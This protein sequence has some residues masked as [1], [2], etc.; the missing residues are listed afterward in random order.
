MGDGDAVADAKQAQESR[1]AALTLSPAEPDAPSSYS[2]RYRIGTTVLYSFTLFATGMGLGGRGAALLSLAK[3]TGI[4]TTGSGSG[5]EE[6]DID[7][8]E[9]TMVGWAMVSTT[10]CSVFFSCSLRTTQ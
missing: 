4:V 3:Q 9:L 6:Q 1:Q 7:L 5:S 10:A 8:S 2:R